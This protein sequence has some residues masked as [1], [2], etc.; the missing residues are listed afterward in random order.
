MI[1]PV[2]F[3]PPARG[4]ASATRKARGEFVFFIGDEGA[5]L[6]Y[7]ESGEVKRR[8]FSPAADGKSTE[9]LKELFTEY[10]AAPISILVD[11]V[12]QSYV[13]HTLPPVSSLGVNKIIQRRLS[14]DFSPDDLK[15]ALSLGAGENWAQ[16][17]ELPAY[18][19]FV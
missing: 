6:C 5:I 10:P 7:I 14:R 1:K 8:L 15:G 11:M 9:T 4:K 17:L 19:T 13:R 16:R 3:K 2:R 12:E 18:F